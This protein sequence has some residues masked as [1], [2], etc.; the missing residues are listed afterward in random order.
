MKDE[1][2]EYQPKAKIVSTLELLEAVFGLIIG[3]IFAAY[4]IDGIFLRLGL[5]ENKIIGIVFLISIVCFIIS[6]WGAHALDKRNDYSKVQDI[7]N[8]K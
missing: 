3:L 7:L 6:S 8:N 5:I 2:K 4:L 1:K